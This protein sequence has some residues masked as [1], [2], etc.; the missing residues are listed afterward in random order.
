MA[1]FVA[2][3]R[4]RPLALLVRWYQQ[5]MG[6]KTGTVQGQRALWVSLVNWSIAL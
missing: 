3:E 1:N 2:T 4:L 5:L 6:E